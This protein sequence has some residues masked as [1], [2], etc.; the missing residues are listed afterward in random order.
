MASGSAA[1]VGRHL[2]YPGPTGPDG[3][4][5]TEDI[6]GNGR[7]DFADIVILF[8]QWNSSDVQDNPSLF[9]FNGNQELDLQ[10]LVAL[11]EI[12]IE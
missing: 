2:E 3:D 1:P 6:N 5:R 7:L 4:G 12:L 9:D 8:E 11:M 10:D